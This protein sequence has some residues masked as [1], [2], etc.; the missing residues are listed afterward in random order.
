MA[1]KP[2]PK[3]E[4]GEK[5]KKV[6]TQL[7]AGTHTPMHFKIRAMIILLAFLGMSNNAISK[8]LQIMHNTVKRWRDRY[9]KMSNELKRIEAE[10]PHKMRSTIEMILSDEQRPGGKPK[11]SDEQ[12]AAIIA[13][14][15]EDPTKLGLPFSHWTPKLLRIEAIK[16][17]IVE[18]ISVRQIGRFLKR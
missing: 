14:A 2:A 17:G 3:I 5:E 1:W 10:T 11:F 4:L 12:V 16:L 13:L 9:I 6:L 15:C 7:K 18:D 8:Y